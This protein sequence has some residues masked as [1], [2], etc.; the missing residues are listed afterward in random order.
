MLEF[1]FG[2]DDAEMEKTAY[3]RRAQFLSDGATLE[4]LVRRALTA[5]P[6]VAATKFL[7]KSGI[8][9]QITERNVE[10]S[11]VGI[12][13]TLY[14][15]GSPAGTVQNGGSRT[16]TA[17]PPEGD[18][19]IKT[20][21]HLIIDE[22]HIAYIYNGRT[23]DGQITGLLQSLFK[24]CNFQTR[25]TQF[26]VM[27][28]A[29]T[30]ALSRLIREGVES[31]DLGIA[32]YAVDARHIQDDI[33]IGIVGRIQSAVALA[34]RS[35]VGSELTS[36]EIEAASELK[37]KMHLDFDKRRSGALMPHVLAKIAEDIVESDSDFKIVTSR[38]QTITPDAISIKSTVHVRGDVNFIE[39]DSAFSAL[40]ACLE[41]WRGQG[42]LL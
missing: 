5:C 40:Q 42:F 3:Y 19:F 8:C 39:N 27:R 21:I 6:D 12:F 37:A 35:V 36:Q 1:A 34:I 31:I 24:K 10:R 16:G 33:S 13:F 4:T 14:D 30:G 20:G 41:E 11:N 18:E 22:N 38:G 29:D 23:N 7:Y 15:E 26:E 32:A 28:W 17:L 9:A 25:D 2:E